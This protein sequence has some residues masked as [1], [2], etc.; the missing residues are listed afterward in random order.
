MKF[1]HLWCHFRTI[2]PRLFQ[3]L[4]F[5]NFAIA[6]FLRLESGKLAQSVGQSPPCL[7]FLHF[8]DKHSLKIFPW[9]LWESSKILFHSKQALGQAELTSNQL[10]VV[11][12]IVFH[13]QEIQFYASAVFKFLSYKSY[14]LSNLCAKGPCGYLLQNPCA[15]SVIL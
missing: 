13:F 3:K 1:C 5:P 15:W 6:H 10:S 8:P 14:S 2:Q 11:W 4:L 12:R 9:I 7:V